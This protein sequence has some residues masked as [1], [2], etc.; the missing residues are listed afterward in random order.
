LSVSR[1]T[2]TNMVKTAAQRQ[3]LAENG[4]PEDGIKYTQKV[5]LTRLENNEDKLELV[6]AFMEERF[7]MEELKMMGDKNG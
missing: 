2:L 6:R 3:F 1:S 7:G 5:H 4:I